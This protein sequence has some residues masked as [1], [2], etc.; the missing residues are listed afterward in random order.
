M[1]INEYYRD[2]ANLNLNGS[3][4]ALVPTTMIVIGN[5]F[6]LKH[7][8]IMIL[9]IPFLLYSL[10]CF[11]LY[12][13]RMRQSIKIGKNLIETNVAQQSIF[14]T[15]HLLVL[16]R[17]SS[18]SSVL[19]YFPNGHFAGEI[20]RYRGRGLKWIFS[21]K[22]FALYN[23]DHHVLCYF[24]VKGKRLIRIE[25]YHQNRSFLGSLEK[26]TLGFRKSKKDLMDSTGRYVGAIEGS[27]IFMDEQILDDG[28]VQVG[29]LRRGWMPV[30]WSSMFP[31]PNTPVLSFKDNLSEEDKLLRMSFLINE[32]Y[33]ER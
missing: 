12:L 23:S 27:S 15:Q 33:I 25:V 10:I 24:K 1:K 26:K 3:I 5:I 21:A 11:Q 2:T 31:E 20:K 8:E 4:A 28:Y 7:K 14:K 16:F 6:F 17:N 22:T 29:R 30:E 13:F 9:A 32:Y 18:S 19:L